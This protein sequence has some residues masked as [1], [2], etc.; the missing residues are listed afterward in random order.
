MALG[1]NMK[2]AVSQNGKEV[3]AELVISSY[4]ETIC[5]LFS[6]VGHFIAFFP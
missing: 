3:L 6:S 5:I 1:M 4:P 2:S